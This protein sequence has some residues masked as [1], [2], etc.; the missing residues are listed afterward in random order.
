MFDPHA[1]TNKG[2]IGLG[3]A[4]TSS[5]QMCLHSSEKWILSEHDDN[6]NDHNSKNSNGKSFEYLR[7]IGGGR[8]IQVM[9][10]QR[11]STDLT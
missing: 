8:R 9:Q 4:M 10:L 7:A 5:H 1:S 2:L 11:I 3:K 6:N